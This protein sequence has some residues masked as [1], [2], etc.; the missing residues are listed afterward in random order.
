MLNATAYDINNFNHFQFLLNSSNEYFVLSFK[1]FQTLEWLKQNN[2]EQYQY[3][4]QELAQHILARL[5]EDYKV[6]RNNL[7]KQNNI[8]V[9]P[10]NRVMLSEI[11]G[12]FLMLTPQW[13][14]E[15]FLVEGPFKDSY[16]FTKTGDA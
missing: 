3:Q 8:K 2:P 7:F 16:K 12:S 10:I 5:E 4:P 14:Y 1:D 11:G 15:G 13:M 6:N 9:F